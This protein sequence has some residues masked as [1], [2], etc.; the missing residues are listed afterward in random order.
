MKMHDCDV[1]ISYDYMFA[2]QNYQ[3]FAKTT[4][5]FT[6]GF[7]VIFIKGLKFRFHCA[8]LL[9]FLIHL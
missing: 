8:D 1:L 2:D 6:S 9:V 3:Q 5:R 4:N 7:E